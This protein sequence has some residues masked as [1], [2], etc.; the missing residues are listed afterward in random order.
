MTTK[1][2]DLTRKVPPK[3]WHAMAQA[4]VIEALQSD[5][6]QGLSAAEAQRRLQRYGPNTLQVLK[7]TP[8]YVVLSRQFVNVLIIILLAAAM[9]ALVIGEVTD[10]VTI[11]MI[12]L[13][14][15]GLG[16]AQ[17]WKAERAIEALQSML[18]PFCQVIR[19]ATPQTIEARL[20]V[21]GDLVQL[22]IGN[23][24]PADL[25][26]LE[27]VNL[28]VNESSLT[29]ESASLAKDTPP[30]DGD[31][32][33]AEQASMVWMGTTVTNGRAIGVV[34]ATGMGTEF[35]R[36]AQLTQTVGRE[37]TPLQRK[38]GLLGKQ[39]GIFSVAVALLVALAGWLLGKPFLVMVLTSI[40][41]AVAVVPEGL[42]AVVT[43]TLA[44]GIRAM[45]KHRALLRRLQAAETLGAASVICTD[46]TG[47][48]TQNE[49]TV[50]QIW[51][52]TGTV[53]VSGVGY[54]P[55]GRF[56]ATGAPVSPGERPD[57]RAL[58]ESGLRCS[59]ARVHRDDQGW[60][61]TGEPTEA[62]LV[63]A[64]CKADLHPEAHPHTVSEFS[65]N[66]QRKRMTIIEHRP[67]G[68]EAYI[69]G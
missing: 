51:L 26:I 3:S 34:V 33:L 37:T 32:P 21:P 42:P 55:Q 38:L 4:A 16:F 49:M 63:V 45:V 29:G 39:L 28:K 2:S 65:F 31:A 14:N 53:E 17:E 6:T 66:S 13:I 10:A 54:R 46:K 61:E 18:S 44:L 58:L 22:R 69:K 11:L 8:W 7:R 35:G 40:S 12:V 9:I 48:L 20:L 19:E 57:L 1:P 59:H 47:T 24:V 5:P 30:V 64:A 41:L 25:R 27:G 67:E 23:R 52:P 15:G 60:H 43:I 62:A 56:T 36:I 50:Q 68:L